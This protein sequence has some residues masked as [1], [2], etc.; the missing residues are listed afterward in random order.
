MF[1][2]GG[3]IG[4]L[5]SDQILLYR[6]VE[7]W[8]ANVRPQL[9]ANCHIQ[10]ASPVGSHQGGIKCQVLNASKPT[11]EFLDLFKRYDADCSDVIPEMD[12]ELRK[13][14]Y[15]VSIPFPKG[16]FPDGMSSSMAAA[17]TRGGWWSSFLDEPRVLIT[18]F[19]VTAVSAALTTKWSQW[20]SL[21]A[22]A[23]VGQ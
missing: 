18:A 22:L 6:D 12:D 2:G 4:N 19:L 8:L 11:K 5:T 10:L 15:H 3:A 14:I 21:A 17:G 13:N 20:T 7:R 16:G 1:G 23:F 9:G